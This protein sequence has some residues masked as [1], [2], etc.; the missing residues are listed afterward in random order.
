MKN[1]KFAANKQRSQKKYTSFL[2]VLD[3]E[4]KQ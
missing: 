2:K 4:T 3:F 1:V